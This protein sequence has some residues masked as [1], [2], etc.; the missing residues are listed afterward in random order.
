MVDDRP[1]E[2][3]PATPIPKHERFITV[4][5]M[6]RTHERAAHGLRPQ[7]VETKVPWIRLQGK[8][9]EAAGPGPQAR[10]RIRIM[11]GCLVLTVD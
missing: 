6:F 1:S 11:V 2:A 8:W 10:V 4:S 7:V 5:S 3:S 9:L